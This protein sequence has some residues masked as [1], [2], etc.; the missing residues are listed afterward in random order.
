[1]QREF[2]RIMILRAIFFLRALR[3]NVFLQLNHTSHAHTTRHRKYFTET[4]A[5]V[6]YTLDFGCVYVRSSE[7]TKQ[8]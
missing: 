8:N 1:M 7:H 2:Q 5:R 6:H 4:R 3:H